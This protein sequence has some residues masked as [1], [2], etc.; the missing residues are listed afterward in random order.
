MTPGAKGTTAAASKRPAVRVDAH[1]GNISPFGVREMA[2]DVWEWTATVVICGGSFDNLYHAVQAS[3]K[4][5]YRC[6]TQP[7]SASNYSPTCG[8]RTVSSPFNRLYNL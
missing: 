1:P 2:G 3:S 8:S 7:A 5:T 6:R 4:G